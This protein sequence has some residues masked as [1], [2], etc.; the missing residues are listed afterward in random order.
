MGRQAKSPRTDVGFAGFASARSA[1][2]RF[3]GTSNIAPT[4]SP[5][6]DLAAVPEVEFESTRP[7]GHAPAKRTRLPVSPFGHVHENGETR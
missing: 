6:Q 3:A 7:L 2:M 4:Q 1:E 5:S